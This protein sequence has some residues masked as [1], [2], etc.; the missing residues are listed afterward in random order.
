MKRSKPEWTPEN[1]GEEFATNVIPGVNNTETKKKELVKKKSLEVDDHIEGI[2]SGNTAI[3]AKAITLIESNSP[4]HFKTA[5]NI[6]QKLLPYTG[7]S[8]RVGITG[9]PGAGKSTFIDALGTYLCEI[10]KKVA[11]LAVDPSSSRSRGSILGDKTRMEELSRQKNAFIRPSPSGGALG[12]VA[13][14]TRETVL[15]CEAAGFDIILIETVGVGQSEIA[16][17]SMVDFFLLL[18]LP[19][20]GDDLQGI[21][22]GSVELADALVVNKA[23]GGNEQRAESTRLSYEQAIH[24][25]LP[26]TEGWQTPVYSCS[27]IEN[28][29]IEKIWDAINEFSETM[30]TTK[31]FFD[32]RKQQQ[33]EWVHSMIAEEIKNMFYTNPIIADN[34]ET[35]EKNI[36]SGNITPTQAVQDLLQMFRINFVA[37][38]PSET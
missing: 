29:G 13:R 17:R 28:K 4:K 12:G 1:A 15:L 16:V 26:A 6:L 25:I 8:I 31:Q 23:D 20:A 2:K 24:F 22:K 21:K 10:G 14:K 38:D 7:N 35:I 5:Q 18:L 9:S 36:S 19:G 34:I 3:L 32:R 33:L 11:V 30:K 37:T 27:S